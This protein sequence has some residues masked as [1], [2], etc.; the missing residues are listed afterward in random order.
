MPVGPGLPCTGTST[1]VHRP[2][3]G[4]PGF[5]ARHP[6]HSPFGAAEYIGDITTNNKGRASNEFKLIVQ[7]AFSSTL[8][9]GHRVRRELN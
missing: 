1:H 7:E 4:F 3:K 8:L 6:T 5:R 9:N 2:P